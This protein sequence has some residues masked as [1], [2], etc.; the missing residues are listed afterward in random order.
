MN[1]NELAGSIAEKTGKTKTEVSE[2]LNALVSTVTETLRTGEEVSIA[3]LGKFVVTN[4][5]ERKGRNPQ[6]GEPITIPA[7]RSPK[8]RASKT[9]KDAV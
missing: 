7:G 5:A 6:T 8:F 4:T 1:K 3:G 9:L 2:M